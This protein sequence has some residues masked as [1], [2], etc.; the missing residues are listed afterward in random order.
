VCYFSFLLLVNSL[1]KEQINQN[2]FPII[3]FCILLY[4]VKLS[5]DLTSCSLRKINEYDNLK[6]TITLNMESKWKMREVF[7]S[8]FLYLVVL[9]SLF[10]SNDH[11][12]DNGVKHA[13]TLLAM[14]AMLM[15]RYRSLSS[16]FLRA[17]YFLTSDFFL[18][19]QPSQWWWCPMN[20][21][22]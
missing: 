10:S 11:A 12:C 5:W 8:F 15:M 4:L 21:L 13:L 1:E 16:Q 18:F 9:L 14:M 22:L 20:S 6:T 3:L 7:I 19:A 2:W 17:S